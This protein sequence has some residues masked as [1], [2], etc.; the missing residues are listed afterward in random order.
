MMDRKTKSTL[1]KSKSAMG[2]NVYYH[3]APLKK[4]SLFCV[5]KCVNIFKKKTNLRVNRF[6]RYFFLSL[7]IS[8]CLCKNFVEKNEKQILSFR[9]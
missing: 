6:N 8:I 7:T 4:Q 2:F 5:L 9:S 3:T 1:E